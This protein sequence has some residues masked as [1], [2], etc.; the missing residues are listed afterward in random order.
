[1]DLECVSLHLHLLYIQL[2][3]TFYIILF[4]LEIN[5]HISEMIHAHSILQKIAEIC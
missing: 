3:C 1:M 2:Y 4:S 5:S